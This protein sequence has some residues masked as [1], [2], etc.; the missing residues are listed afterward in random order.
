MSPYNMEETLSTMRFGKRAKMIVNKAKINEEKSIAEYKSLLAA[1]E[2]KIKVSRCFSRVCFVCS[3]S[4][5]CKN[6]DISPL[7][8]LSITY[9]SVPFALLCLSY[10]CHCSSVISDSLLVLRHFQDQERIIAALRDEGGYPGPSAA[11]PVT[12]VGEEPE[13]GDV[14]TG[15]DGVGNGDANGSGGAEAANGA[16][17]GAGDARP[18]SPTFSFSEGSKGPAEGNVTFT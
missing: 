8:F 18:P 14:K 10:T 16:S 3:P 6:A 17:G 7:L 11:N 12:T 2:N 13:S 5:A 15:G 4:L 1:A 9:D